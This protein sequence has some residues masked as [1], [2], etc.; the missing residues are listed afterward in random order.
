MAHF[1]R[2]NENNIVDEIIVIN[3]EDCQNL[4]FPESESVGQE[5]ITSIGLSGNWKQTS[6][7]ANFRKKYS[8]IGDTFDET[9]NAFITPKPFTSWILNEDT[10][11][12]ESPIERPTDGNL[13]RWN[14]DEQSWEEVITE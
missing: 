4:D 13:Y 7:N 8:G 12:W 5:F 6:Y 2:I 3:N 9:R 1:A 11:I 14:E 10:C